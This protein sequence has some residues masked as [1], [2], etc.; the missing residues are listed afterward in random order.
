[1]ASILDLFNNSG[2]NIDYISPDK[3]PMSQ[4]LGEDGSKNIDKSGTYYKNEYKYGI[5]YPKDIDKQI[6]SEDPFQLTLAN[7]QIST[8]GIRNGALKIAK[9]LPKKT[10]TKVKNVIDQELSG[11]RIKHFESVIDLYGT[12]LI[13]ITKQSTNLVDDM[14]VATGGTRRGGLVGTLASPFNKVKEKIKDVIG[15]PETAIPTFIVDEGTKLLGSGKRLF[16]ENRG[17]EQNTMEYLAD[18]RKNAAGSIVGKFLKENGSGTPKQIV[19]NVVGS[20]GQ[21]A[22]GAIRRGLFGRGTTLETN[23]PNRNASQGTIYGS[24]DN[25]VT[26]S[27]DADRRYTA[28][29]EQMV[30]RESTESPL[31]NITDFKPS[32]EW[33]NAPS[34]TSTTLL[35]SA[36]ANPKNKF[37]GNRKYDR[38]RDYLLNPDQISSVYDGST[39]NR[40]DKKYTQGFRTKFNKRLFEIGNESNTYNEYIDTVI[41]EIGSVRFNN[42]A[43][44][45]LSETLSPSWSSFRMVGSPFNSYVYDSIERSVSFNI[46]LYALNPQQHKQ[47][48]DNIKLLTGLVYPAA[49]SSGAGAVTAPVTTITIGDIYVNKFGFVESLSYTVDDES[50]WEL[51]RGEAEV[52]EYKKLFEN[53]YLKD[54][55]F[56]QLGLDKPDIWGSVN[57]L[58]LLK[59]YKA[60]KSIEIQIGFKFIESRN[61]AGTY[62]FKDSSN[63]IVN[64]QPLVGDTTPDVVRRNTLGG[65]FG[66]FSSPATMQ[67]FDKIT[68]ATNNKFPNPPTRTQGA[69]PSV[70]GNPVRNVPSFNPG[71]TTPRLPRF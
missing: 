10:F 5:N 31:F 67:S 65:Q 7:R 40:G 58:G 48:W 43:I 9:I 60:P 56:V 26:T 50:T 61:N 45:G 3:T 20:V 12:E 51:G 8:A 6:N 35:G 57:N 44:T 70:P 34:P 22:K 21:A 55:N 25:S 42:V 68:N 41:V 1:M 39:M 33:L 30:Q 46:K 4:G 19:K 32:M 13:R 27:P 16:T 11:L 66:K 36:G 23:E 49:Y 69:L 54:G 52:N 47:N 24:A 38:L 28:T 63:N 53:Y 37:N 14:K 59:N 15:F 29:M 71:S 62:G 17:A 18:I 64:L 2:K